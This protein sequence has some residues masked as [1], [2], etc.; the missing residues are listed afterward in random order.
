MLPCGGHGRSRPGSVGRSRGTS[1]LA[2]CPFPQGRM[3][4]PQGPFKSNAVE[5]PLDTWLSAVDV[6]FSAGAL[7]DLRELCK[8]PMAQKPKAGL[9]MRW[10]S[11]K[12]RMLKT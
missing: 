9:G 4:G 7:T 3:Q 11:G 10:V 5:R 6:A 12:G 2:R 8:L 1:S